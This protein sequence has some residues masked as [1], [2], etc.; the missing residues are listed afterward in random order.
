MSKYLVNL[1]A[2]RPPGVYIYIY[3][4]VGNESTPWCTKHNTFNFVRAQV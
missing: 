4:Y 3:I 2:S 1:S